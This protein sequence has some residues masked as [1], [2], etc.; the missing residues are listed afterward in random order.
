MSGTPVKFASGSYVLTAADK[1]ALN[2]IVADAVSGF[3]FELYI[4]GYADKDGA[5][6]AN[7]VLSQKRA[8]VVAAY[9]KQRL[10]A[11]NN[12]SII[13][14]AYGAGVLKTHSDKS[15]NRIVAVTALGGQG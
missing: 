5:A 8:D 13:V 15:L 3:K 12:T 7:K 6:A 1:S 4:V 9:V 14:Y 2:T 10:H 11:L